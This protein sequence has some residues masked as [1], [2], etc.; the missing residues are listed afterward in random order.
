M[1][2]DSKQKYRKVNATLD[3]QPK[4]GP[5]P[6]DQFFPWMVICGV[7]YY[8]FKVALGMNWV[9]TGA[10]AAW[11]MST[12]WVLTGNRSWKFLSKFVSVPT[13]VRAMTTYRR[14]LNPQSQ[15]EKQR[16]GKNQSRKKAR[17]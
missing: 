9:W 5:F 2:S 12:W 15:V 1:Q 17:R 4:I 3:K 6:A 11:G 14:L 7:F 13:W 16:N 10:L 8:L